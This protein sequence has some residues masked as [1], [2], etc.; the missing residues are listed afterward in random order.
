MA[1]QKIDGW[2]VQITSYADDGYD[3]LAEVDTRLFRTKESAE[4]FLFNELH[5]FIAGPHS[6]TKD[7]DPQFVAAHKNLKTMLKFAEEHNSGEFS[8]RKNDWVITPFKIE[9]DPRIRKCR[10]TRKRKRVLESDEE[11]SAKSAA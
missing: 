3:N 6:C 9:T 5:E 8:K 10:A 1:E 2:M 4:A 11:E 7:S